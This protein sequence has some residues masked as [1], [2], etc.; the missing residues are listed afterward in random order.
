MKTGSIS[1][2]LFRSGVAAILG[3]LLLSPPVVLAATYGT[4]ANVG[5][6]GTG[7]GGTG[8]SYPSPSCNY[9]YD[10][11]NPSYNFNATSASST[12][13][14][15]SS[16]NG[17]N[18]PASVYSI[19][20]SSSTAGIGNLHAYATATSLGTDPFTTTAEAHARAYWNDTLTIASS[21]LAPG[22]PVDLIGNL[23]LGGSLTISD[24]TALSDNVNAQ[25]SFGWNTNLYPY[26]T[27]AQPCQASITGGYIGTYPN[28]YYGLVTSGSLPCDNP[29]TIHTAVGDVVRINGTLDVQA[30]A[31]SGLT[32]NSWVPPY[33]PFPPSTATADFSSTGS[34]SLQSPSGVTFVAA[35]NATYAPVPL[36]P[37]VWL[38]GSGLLG[39]V[40][41]AR[42]KAR[43]TRTAMKHVTNMR[44]E[45]S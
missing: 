18:D 23:H 43:S 45:V 11:L 38:F 42:R 41:I 16:A 4:G 21:T 28:G 31:K 36:P 7:S 37:A 35:S 2:S 10:S 40:G 25:F 33:D 12:S 8:C 44:G 13:P 17:N 1:H 20:S 3:G 34:L 9:G 24:P 6:V 27:S 30:Y 39:L 32:S 29:F 26:T 15:S 14:L 19:G 5:G 22:T